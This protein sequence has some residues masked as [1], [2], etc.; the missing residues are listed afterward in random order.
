MTR[1]D[2]QPLVTALLKKR[3]VHHAILAVMSG[4]G[5]MVWSAAAGEADTS[6]RP[7]TLDT[8][9][10]V[11]SVTKLFIAAVALRF[12]ETGRIELDQPFTTRLRHGLADGLHVLNGV[13]RT[14][15]ITVRHLLNHTSGLPDYIEDK[16]KK[17]KRFFDRLLA[18]GDRDVGIEEVCSI[19]RHD[20]TPHFAPRPLTPDRRARARYSDTNFRLLIAIIEAVS[21]RRWRDVL[22]TELLEPLGLRRTWAAGGKPLDVA[23]VPA[24]LW[25]GRATLD[26]PRLLASFG[27]L[28]STV[29]DQLTFMRALVTGEAFRYAKTSA[30]MRQDWHPFGFDPST[31]RLPGWPI[32]YGLGTMRFALPR[33][34]TP[35]SPV[36]AVVGHTGSTGCWLFY[37]PELDVYICGDVSQVTAGAVPFRAVPRVLKALRI[38]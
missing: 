35:F 27:D 28:Y 34:L 33:W 3:G 26:R 22:A 10:F 1:V 4:N 38:R 29:T 19:V 11:A 13:D 36:P 8:P 24:A 5:T 30:L 9:Y 23:P 12:A 16:P 17:G 31:P 32:E 18:E 2:L 7:M 15:K 20:L 37:C 25:H 21:G 6:G 14:D